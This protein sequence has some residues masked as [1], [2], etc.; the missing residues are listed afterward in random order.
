MINFIAAPLAII[1]SWV[2]ANTAGY[3]KRVASNAII[4]I[5]FSIAN[6][7]GPQT[8]Q[9]R[10]APDYI[11]AKIT[12][13]GVAGG[14]MCISASLRV[15]YGLRNSKSIKNREAQWEEMNAEGIDESQRED[16]SDSTDRQN[17]AF[18]YVY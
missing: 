2:G 10:D 18:V 17:P 3:T 4:A 16:R 11:P 15:L 7:I 13:F 9:S 8:F 1:Y 5:G 14:A 6:I 12:I